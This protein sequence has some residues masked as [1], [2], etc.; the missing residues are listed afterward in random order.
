M[1]GQDKYKA[2]P[3]AAYLLDDVRAELLDGTFSIA[4]KVGSVNSLIHRHNSWQNPI[5]TSDPAAMTAAIALCR[6]LTKPSLEVEPPTND[7]AWSS[8]QNDLS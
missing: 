6:A 1:L 4:S 8:V 7:S 2:N 5:Q 3:I